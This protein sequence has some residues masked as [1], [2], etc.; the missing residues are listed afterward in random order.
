MFT[1]IDILKIWQNERAHAHLSEQ[2]RLHTIHRIYI[3]LTCGVP[4]SVAGRVD[5]PIGRDPYN[6]IRMIADAGQGNVGNTRHA[7]SR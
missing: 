1:C 6:R 7:V 4:H 3:S 2:F 5:V